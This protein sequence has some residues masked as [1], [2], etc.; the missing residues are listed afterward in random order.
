MNRQE[1][2][3]NLRKFEVSSFKKLTR[4]HIVAALQ[5]WTVD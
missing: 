2:S 4:L 3:K 1:F 5:S